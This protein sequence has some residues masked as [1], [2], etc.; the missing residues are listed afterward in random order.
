M[1]HPACCCLCGA[2][3]HIFAPYADKPHRKVV[4]CTSDQCGLHTQIALND[5][6]PSPEV[7]ASTVRM[8][9][10]FQERRT[11]YLAQVQA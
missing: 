9:E 3:V 10:R 11:A 8:M 4:E 6:P 7:I 5:Y 2:P 1:N